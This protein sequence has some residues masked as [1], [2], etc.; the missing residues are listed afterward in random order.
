MSRCGIMSQMQPI[1]TRQFADAP[2]SQNEEHPPYLG[3][4]LV[5]DD[6]FEEGPGIELTREE[7]ARHNH[8]G[9]CWIIIHGKV[10]N[11]T[12]WIPYHPGRDAI[13]QNAGH[14]STA[15][16]EG[17]RCVFVCTPIGVVVVLAWLCQ[18]MSISWLVGWLVG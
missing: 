10:Y 9:D 5:D 7:V 3:Q 11:V 13:L 18:L 16:F 4:N 17:M 14:D 6:D 2:S 12:Q 1:R 8:R 15:L